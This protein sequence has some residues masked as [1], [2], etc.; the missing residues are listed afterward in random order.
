[1]LYSATSGTS[2]IA[3][4][5]WLTGLT[6]GN[7]GNA[8]AVLAVASFGFGMLLG[9]IPIKAGLRMLVG[10][11]VLF[12]A[13]AIANGLLGSVRGGAGESEVVAGDS[14]RL[15]VPSQGPAFDP[16]AGAAVPSN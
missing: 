10:L 13:P 11:F 1:M 14:D 7:L 2:V 16:Y 8:L 9:Q 12:S 15:R 3:S 6:L 5:Q 4:V